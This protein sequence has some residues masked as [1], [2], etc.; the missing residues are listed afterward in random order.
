[1]KKLAILIPLFLMLAVVVKAQPGLQ[2]KQHYTVGD[3]DK[4]G[5]LE[6]TKIYVGQV[7]KLNLLIPYVPFNQKGETVSLSGMGI[8]STKD[9]NGYI[10][11]LD[12]SGSSHNETLDETMNNILPYADKEDIVRTILFIQDVIERIE[13]GL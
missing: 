4:L 9:N 10:K 8:P 3:L 1:M 12:A 6:L 13:N 2:T 11:A 5:K 7:Q